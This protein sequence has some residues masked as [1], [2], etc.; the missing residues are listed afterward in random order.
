VTHRTI[1][2]GHFRVLEAIRD[3]ATI[4]EIARDCPQPPLDQIL[5]ELINAGPVTG[6]LR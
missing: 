5:P 1:S 2:G 6:A 4:G 3:N